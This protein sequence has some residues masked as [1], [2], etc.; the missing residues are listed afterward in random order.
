MTTTTIT[1]SARRNTSS[2][3]RIAVSFKPWSVCGLMSAAAP[4]FL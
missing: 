2:F 1:V 4:F 3:H